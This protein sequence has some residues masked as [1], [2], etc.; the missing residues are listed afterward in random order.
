MAW[1]TIPNT[2]VAGIAGKWLGVRWLVPDEEECVTSAVDG[3]HELRRFWRE[4]GRDA[5]YDHY[6]VDCSEEYVGR[7]ESE[8]NAIAE[9]RRMLRE[10]E[11]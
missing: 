4:N 11:L 8:A 3:M 1:Y 7:Y 10:G 9:W 2:G 5:Y 6:R